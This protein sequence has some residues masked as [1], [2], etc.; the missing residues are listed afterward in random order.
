[1]G[2]MANQIALLSTLA[3]YERAERAATLFPSIKGQQEKA[4]RL[5]AR[6]CEISFACGFNPGREHRHLTTVEFCRKRADALTRTFP[7]HVAESRK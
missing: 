2:H 6:L 5:H 1:M 4:D 3:A 7:I